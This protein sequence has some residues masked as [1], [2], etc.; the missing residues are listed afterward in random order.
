[1]IKARMTR[2]GT[3]TLLL[4]LSRE[5]V[6]RLLDDQPIHITAEQLAEMEL[7]TGM[8]VV[9]MAGETEAS[10]AAQLG[11]AMPQPKPGDKHV[12]RVDHG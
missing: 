6:L 11:A 5:N 1:M 7:P 3:P 12:V 9:L 10:I 2:A 4:G 8:E